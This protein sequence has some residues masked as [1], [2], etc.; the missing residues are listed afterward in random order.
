MTHLPFPVGADIASS[1][2]DERR[3]V[4]NQL[5]EERRVPEIHLDQM[6][7]GDEKEGQ[8]FALLVARERAS[9]PVL[10]T[11]VPRKSP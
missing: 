1:E 4:P 8:T 6:F 11:V 3:T 9:R 7:M 2:E 5:G 10:S